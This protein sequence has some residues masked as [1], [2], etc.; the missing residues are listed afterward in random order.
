MTPLEAS[1]VEIYVYKLWS[2]KSLFSPLGFPCHPN[3][4]E[5][6]QAM[7]TKPKGRAL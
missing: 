7:D 1:S 5:H 3:S 6:I 2:I 4:H